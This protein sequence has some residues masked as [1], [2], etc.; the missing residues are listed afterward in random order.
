M[1]EEQRRRWR[2]TVARAKNGWPFDAIQ[3]HPLTAR[4]IAVTSSHPQW[5]YLV[6]F[7][8][9]SEDQPTAAEVDMLVSYLEEYKARWYG[10]A[11]EGGD[12]RSFLD[13]RPLDVDG[14]ANGVIFHKYGPDDWGY[15]RRTYE[16]SFVPARTPLASLYP[17]WPNRPLSLLAV[18]DRAHGMG[19]EPPRSWSEW[20]TNHPEIF[21]APS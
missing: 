2:E 9:E 15:R 6:S 18:M 12:Y 5:Y 16:H 10:T 4:R 17:S 21:G 3:D 7:D 8:Y 19:T 1:F 14:G 20:K 11:E 13:S